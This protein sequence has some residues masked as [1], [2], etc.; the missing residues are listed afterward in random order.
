MPKNGGG[1]GAKK[2]VQPN[3]RLVWGS[4][5]AE[6]REIERERE[7]KARKYTQA[8]GESGR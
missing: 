8:K 3:W 4:Q 6:R 5:G 1:G 2:S 7:R